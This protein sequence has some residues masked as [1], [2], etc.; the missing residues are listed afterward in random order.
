MIA[1]RLGHSEILEQP[2]A[3]GIANIFAALDVSVERSG[4]EAVAGLVIAGRTPEQWILRSGVPIA[5]ALVC[6]RA[7]G[8]LYRHGKRWSFMGGEGGLVSARGEFR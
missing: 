1:S 8:L 2:G 6:A 3:G 4:R 7:S 5:N